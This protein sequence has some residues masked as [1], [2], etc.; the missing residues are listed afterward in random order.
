MA[1]YI[2]GIR[3]APVEAQITEPEL[4]AWRARWAATCSDKTA[5]A[6]CALERD[7]A[8]R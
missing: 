1:S 4:A 2:V 8:P 5:R 7:F 6:L 3:P